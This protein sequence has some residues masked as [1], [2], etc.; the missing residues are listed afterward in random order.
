MR[1]SEETQ[2]L[3]HLRN[4]R[5][6]I[7]EAWHGTVSG[8]GFATL[9]VAEIR[10]R[11]GGLTDQVI[12]VLFTDPLERQKAREIGATLVK[13]R[14]LEPETLGRTLEVLAKELVKGLSDDEAAALQ[15]RLAELLP[16][17]AVGFT[18]QARRTVLQEQE[19]I[20]S[21]LIRD[22]ERVAE[23]LRESE[24]GLAEAQS[25]ARLGHWELDLVQDE[26]RWSEEI[27]RIFGVDRE[28][29]G[30]QL[31]AFREYVHPDDLEM[32]DRLGQMAIGGEPT[33]FEHRIVRPDG[34]V[35]HVHQRV[36]PESADG[37]TI[38]LLG[39][40]QDVTGR[41]QLEEELRE[42]RE[43]FQ[44]IFEQ[45]PLGISIADPERK[46]LET[47]PAYQEL[48]GYTG[49]ELFGKPIA[50][51][52]HPDDVPDDEE[53]NRELHSGKLDRY[54]KEKRYVRRDGEV[55]WIQ[56]T[57][58]PV[59]DAG[60]E[61][62]FLIGLV[63]DITERK[64]AER[65]LEKSEERYRSL[66]QNVS[67]LIMLVDAEGTV[68]YISPS[69]KDITGYDPEEMLGQNVFE[70]AHPEDRAGTQAALGELA[71]NLGE[72]GPSME[73]RARHKDG[74]WLHLEGVASNRLDDP[75]VEGIVV[76]V[77]DVTERR[78]AEERLRTMA[79]AA[80]E[81]IVITHEGEVLEVN[82][83]LSGMLGYE[84]REMIGRQVLDFISTEY[85]ERVRERILTGAQDV[86]E[87]QGLRKDG[88][89]IELEARGR[90]FSYGGREVR[91]STVR[92]IGDRKKVE[93]DLRESN[94]RLEELAT[95]KAD[96][97]AMVAHE[98]DSPLATVRGLVEM[99]ETG[100]SITEEQ[101]RL[102]SVIDSEAEKLFHLVSDVREAAAAERE[103]FE[104][105]FSKISVDELLEDAAVFAETI[106]GGC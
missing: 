62:R 30:A 87:L 26:L 16:E 90:N 69:L 100:D 73:V 6:Q 44:A 63:E 60:G 76:N 89:R 103:D 51:L 91:V 53:S 72:E 104:V 70:H 9:S 77:R 86:Y 12:G 59:R 35:R 71:E 52:S 61:V 85:R 37:R 40:V 58:A 95:M 23:T 68:R 41:K 28:E 64:A 2:L 57:V 48:T 4:R 25:L 98:L 49:E 36:E 106:P 81:G 79:D 39:T 7:A 21:A 10:R 31:D 19:S 38:R 82:Q 56:P 96:F 93:E 13:L 33:S 66:V 102:L 47:N 43:R 15:Q 99:L 3:D 50:E 14:L 65:E 45:A 101:R 27:F 94:R 1:V 32:V 18:E 78:E 92:D 42:S 8:V 105:S 54:R 74:S 17:I 34:G 20:R 5:E 80:F 75:A 11:L 55:I 24:A 84:S 67:D 22:Y 83:A 97:T 46:L 29:F 88:A